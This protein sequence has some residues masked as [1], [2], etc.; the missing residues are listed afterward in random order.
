MTW[1][2]LVSLKA[3]IVGN[4][5]SSAYTLTSHP[6]DN[7]EVSITKPIFPLG[8]STPLTFVDKK[9]LQPGA[10]RLELTEV[11]SVVKM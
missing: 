9:E 6:A 7:V 8:C 1:I 4:Y 11:R 2:I 10:E 5:A 3:N